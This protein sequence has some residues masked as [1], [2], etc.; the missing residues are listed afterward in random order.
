[1]IG[2]ELREGDLLTVP[3]ALRLLP[4]S[5][6][7]LYRLIGAGHIPAVRLPSLGR[8]PGRVLVPRAGLERF[9]RQ[10][11]PASQGDGTPPPGPLDPDEILRCVE[12]G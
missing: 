7:Q 8:G 10:L 11:P 9:I 4:V 12:G 3:A 6:A 1:M 5:R 2:E